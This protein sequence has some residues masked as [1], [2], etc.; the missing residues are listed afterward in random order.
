MSASD[1]VLFFGKYRSLEI[2][3][4]D[5]FIE[6]ISTYIAWYVSHG[7]KHPTGD[8]EEETNLR[9]WRKR[10]QY[11][12]NRHGVC[13]GYAL[14]W[15]YDFC[16]LADGTK[17]RDLV[18]AKDYDAF[19]AEYGCHPMTTVNYFRERRLAHFRT[20]MCY[21]KARGESHRADV[22]DILDKIPR[23]WDL[24]LAKTE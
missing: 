16:D 8:S 11:V 20:A 2:Q 21:Q 15:V 9:E 7:Y 13:I 1:F 5:T 19:Y 12:A 10:T 24:K 23:F 4:L 18:M 17:N 14:T 22:L 6:G 3:A